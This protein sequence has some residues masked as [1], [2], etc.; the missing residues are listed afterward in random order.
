M[1]THYLKGLLACLLTA[2]L[3]PAFAQTAAVENTDQATVL[4]DRVHFLSG[5]LENPHAVHH[6]RF[7][8]LRGQDVLLTTLNSV[9]YGQQWRLEYRIDSG[10]WKAK[11]GSGPQKL[12]GLAVGATVEVKVLAV[13]GVQPQTISYNL[14]FGSYPHMRYDFHHQKDFLPIPHGR[15]KPE[16]LATQALTEAML[17]VTFTDNKGHPLEGGVVAFTFLP[18]VELKET[19]EFYLSDR[20]GKVKELIRFNACEGGVYAEPFV[21]VNGGRNTWATRYKVGVYQAVNFLPGAIADK[22]HTFFFGHICKRWLI[23]WSKN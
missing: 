5:E 16:F 13:D 1:K 19:T 2:C 20:D 12:Q 7:T 10:E 4:E 11:S 15:T 21:H 14:V 9:T 17:D 6:Y 8:A 22:P 3:F 23:N 18:N